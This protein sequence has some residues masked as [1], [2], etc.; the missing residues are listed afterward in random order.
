MFALAPYHQPPEARP[1]HRLALRFLGLTRTHSDLG[2]PCF[3]FTVLRTNPRLHFAA[4][5]F[6][7]G[8]TSGDAFPGPLKVA[9]AGGP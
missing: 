7:G 2:L 3:D 8:T 1:G 4:A 6:G 9:E 5:F